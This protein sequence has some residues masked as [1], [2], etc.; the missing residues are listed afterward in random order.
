MYTMLNMI[1]GVGSLSSPDQS[2]MKCGRN[3]SVFQPLLPLSR[4]IYISSSVAEHLVTVGVLLEDHRFDPGGE[5]ST[6]EL[7]SCA[8]SYFSICSIPMLLQ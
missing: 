8:D 7:T 3:L 4:N 1:F 6:P 2:Q 5:F